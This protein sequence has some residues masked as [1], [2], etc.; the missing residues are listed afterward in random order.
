[1]P[2]NVFKEF[3]VGIH[4]RAT[5]TV[6]IRCV[7]GLFHKDLTSSSFGVNV[8]HAQRNWVDLCNTSRNGKQQEV[9]PIS[10][11]E[12]GSSSTYSWTTWLQACASHPLSCLQQLGLDTKPHSDQ[13]SDR[14]RIPAHNSWALE[15]AITVFRPGPALVSI[16]SLLFV[17]FL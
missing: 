8:C 5:I 13:W 3:S 10:H 17:R 9:D 15:K 4:V 7:S 1:M 11:L 6:L 2:R 16:F 12:C 14:S